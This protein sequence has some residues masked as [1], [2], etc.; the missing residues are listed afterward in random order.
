MGIFTL[1]KQRFKGRK[2]AP[3]HL[4]SRNNE[5]SQNFSKDQP[6]GECEFVVFD[7]ELTGLSLKKDEVVAIGGVKVKNLQIQCGETFYALVKPESQLYSQST[8]IHRITPT[9]LLEAQP[10]EE[11]LP[12]FLE[13]CGDAY[14]VGHY[15]RMDL[16]FVNKA[17]EKIF[18]GILKTPYLD[19]MRLAMAY[20]ELKH[21]HYYDHYN[22]GTSYNL[23]TLCKQYGLPSFEGHNALHDSLQAA[24]LFLF[25]TKKMRGFGT[26]TLGDF[27][28]AG[29]QWKIL[30]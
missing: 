17:S 2:K 24:Y 16:G 29:R 3:H 20:N 12:K 25:L 11:V 21:G 6:I 30:L 19:T 4:I 28:K 8:L 1:L 27:L 23:A 15:V 13:F 5:F 26:K 22:I 10:M 9:E 14:L 18:G 7:T